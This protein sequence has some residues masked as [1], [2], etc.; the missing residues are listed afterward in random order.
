[1]RVGARGLSRTLALLLAL[2]GT[3]AAQSPDPTPSPAAD[4]PPGRALVIAGPSSLGLLLPLGGRWSL[5]PDVS[6]T[7]TTFK[8]AG[9][10]SRITVESVGLSV[11]YAMSRQAPLTTYL[12]PRAAIS[13]TVFND[14]SHTD[15]WI[16]DALYG[17]DVTVGDRFS[18]FGEGGLRFTNVRPPS[19]GGSNT[20]SSLSL[21]S[22]LGVTVRF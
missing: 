5:R 13:R 19:A 17:A 9:S 1:M 6:L 14:G 3:L 15:T 16:F 22:H 11:L 18:V 10:T 7:K 8:V 4:A 2:S 21:R 20:S 12:A